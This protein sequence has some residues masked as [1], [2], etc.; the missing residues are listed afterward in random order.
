MNFL[1]KIL[2]QE[3]LTIVESEAFIH[4]IAND[5]FSEVELGGILTAIQMRGLTLDEFKGFRN[6]LELYADKVSLYTNE[7]ID[8]CGTGGDGKDTFNISTTTAFVLSAMGYKVIKHGNYGVSSICGSSNVL[9]YLGYKFTKDEQV[10]NRQLETQNICFIHAPLFH[11]VLKKVAPVRKQ[12]GVGTFFNAMGPLL[13]PIQPKFQLTGTYCLELA[14]IYQVLLKDKRQAFKVVYALDGYDELT[15][16]ADARV[17]GNNSDEI[18]NANSFGVETSIADNLKGG[19]IEQSANMLRSILA[20]KASEELINVVA[21]N[22][23]LGMSCFHPEKQYKLL[24]EEA[25]TFILSG[26]AIK[27][28]KQLNAVEAII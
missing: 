26:Q 21:A 8:V 2:K 10:L 18:L 9:E 22:T 19:S 17:L 7:A 4:A 1:K 24:F 27:F 23:A 6:A 13:N 11:P 15:L 20:G 25:K 14:K 12:L 3:Q 16:T 28:H 5:E